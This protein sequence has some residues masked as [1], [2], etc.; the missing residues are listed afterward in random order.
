MTR[1]ELAEILGELAGT[2]S[3]CWSEQSLG[4]FQS[5]QALA[6][7]D[8]AADRILAAL[9]VEKPT[10]PASLVEELRAWWDSRLDD[11][12]AGPAGEGL[13]MMAWCAKFG[14]ILS[15]HEARKEVVLAEGW[16]RAGKLRSIKW[17][18]Q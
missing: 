12:R 11:R 9:A 8:K 4:I 1:E 18:S 5:E 17:R 2:A 15:R 7:C 3:V 14:E 10:A 13:S 6:A 16:V